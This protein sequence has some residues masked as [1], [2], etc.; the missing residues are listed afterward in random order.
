M[1][2]TT[3]CS[4]RRR[5][6][7]HGF[8]AAVLDVRAADRCAE[9]FNAFENSHDIVFYRG[10]SPNSA[11]THLCIRQADRIFLLARAGASLPR[12]TPRD[13]GVQ[14]AGHGRSANSFSLHPGEKP[15][16][17][18][19]PEDVSL[20]KAEFESHH[21]VPSGEAGGYAADL[22]GFIAGR[23]VGV[24]LRR[25][26]RARLCAYRCVKALMEASVPFDH[27][28]GT[29]MGAI[30][31]AGLA[32][33]WGLDELVARIRDAFVDPTPLSDFTVPMIALLRG[34]QVSARC[35]G[36]FR[37]DTHR[38]NAKPFF[39]VS[40]DLTTGRIHVHR[41][42]PLWRALRASVAVPGILPP[43]TH[44]GHL[45]VDGGVMN[46]L[47]VDV[48]AAQAQGPVIASDVTGEIDLHASD[49]RYGERSIWWLLWQRMRGSPSIVSILTRSGTVGSEAQRRVV[50]EQADFLLNRRCPTLVCAI[51][52]P[53]DQ[54]IAE[55]YAHARVTIDDTACR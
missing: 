48:M 34:K 27:L 22:R 32:L 54:A 45:L 12:H 29:S 46:N 28:G 31:A 33:E 53:L 18:V 35:A 14:D 47:P 10:D 41:T 44:H 16:G 13:A 9:W 17:G 3:S 20:R 7:W 5:A 49:P 55:G 38:G 19:Y 15:I 42:G 43:V 52:N 25:R 36:A 50:R 4:N 2:A 11:W 40:S 8:R 6:R 21:H 39:C 30:I 26:W 51:G 37:R 1:R 23:A 24:V